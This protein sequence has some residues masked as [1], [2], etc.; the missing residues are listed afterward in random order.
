VASLSGVKLKVAVVAD[1]NFIVRNSGP[2]ADEDR[3]ALSRIPLGYDQSM[4]GFV[5]GLWPY[6]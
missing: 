4:A 2:P 5:R 3:F 6:I 1:A